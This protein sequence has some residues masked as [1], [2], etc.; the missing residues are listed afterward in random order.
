VALLGPISQLL[1]WAGENHAAIRSARERF[2][3]A[4]Q[5]AVA[6]NADEALA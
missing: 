3:H 6:L 4:Q 2:D 5:P 1:N